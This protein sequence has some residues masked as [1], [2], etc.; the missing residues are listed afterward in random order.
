RIFEPFF[1][2][3]PAGKG[4]GLGLHVAYTVVQA[5]G[6]RIDVVSQPGE[7][8]EFFIRLPIDGPGRAS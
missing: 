1:T 8:T 4:T 5:H 7:G 6:G 2:T 3:K